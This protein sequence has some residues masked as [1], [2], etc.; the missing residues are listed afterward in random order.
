MHWAL[1]VVI[2]CIIIAFIEP[3]KLQTPQDPWMPR[4]LQLASPEARAEYYKIYDGSFDLTKQQLED[5]L[6]QWAKKQ[7]DEVSKAF[8]Q[9]LASEEEYAQKRFEVLSKRIESSDGSEQAKQILL[10]MLQYEQLKNVTIREYDH[11]ITTFLDA[12]PQNVQDEVN[13][14]WSKI[15]P[16]NIN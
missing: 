3:V 6:R 1:A 7:G 11:H 10:D 2:P 13:K 16:A 5:K 14:L 12:Y 8:E 4:F 15:D 9:Y